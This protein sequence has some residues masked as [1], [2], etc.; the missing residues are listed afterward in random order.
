MSKHLRLVEFSR[1]FS[2]KRQKKVRTDWLVFST[3]TNDC[4]RFQSSTPGEEEV[5]RFLASTKG[6]LSRI[7]LGEVV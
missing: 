7:C 3:R 4:S 1:I 6:T 2:V 5:K